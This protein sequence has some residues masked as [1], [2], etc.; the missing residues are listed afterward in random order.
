VA[1]IYKATVTLV[2]PSGDDRD[3]DTVTQII[4]R[5]ANGAVIAQNDNVAS[6]QHFQTRERIAHTV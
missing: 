6:G 3:Y 1:Q 4:V 5:G 2:L